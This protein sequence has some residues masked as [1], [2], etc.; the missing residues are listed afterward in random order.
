MKIQKKFT[1]GL[2]LM[3][4]FSCFPALSLASQAQITDLEGRVTM[5]ESENAEWQDAR[6]NAQLSIGYELKAGEKGRATIIFEAGHET[7]LEN[8]SSIKINELDNQTNL[9]LFKGKLH[10]KVKELS[11]TETYQITTPQ[12]ICGVR[13][14]EFIVTA[15]EDTHIKVI[16]GAVSFTEIETGQTTTVPAGKQ[17]RI[18]KNQAPEKPY[19]TEEPVDNDTGEQTEATDPEETPAEELADASE[20]EV[21]AEPQQEELDLAKQELRNEIRSA[22]I[23]IRA[24]VRESQNVIEHT[25]EADSVTGRSLKD[26]HGNLVR[27]EQHLMRPDSKT[28]QFINI[29]K[30]DNYKYKGRMNVTPT[31]ARLDSF[32][33]RVTFNRN[34]PEKISG[35]FDFVKDID[36]SDADFHPEIFKMT[37]N[38]QHDRIEM[39]SKWNYTDENMDEPEVKIIS[40]HKDYNGTWKIDS[41][42]DQGSAI[43]QPDD[44]DKAEMWAISPA[45]RVY[46]PDTS[47]EYWIRN[48]IENWLINNDGNVFAFK[49]L[50]DGDINPFDILK[51]IAF[52]T[53]YT[54]RHNYNEDHFMN[55]KDVDNTTENRRAA[56][57]GFN[58]ADN[59]LYRNFDLVVTPDMALNVLEEMAKNIDVSKLDTDE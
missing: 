25:R 7:R 52:Q 11:A 46:D 8:N 24:E 43:G 5:R 55:E 38:N 16:S 42:A 2:V 45:M 6:L 51:R 35:W 59:F 48:G 40:A 41:D 58:K 27:V 34:I 14:T 53:S 39:T 12:A 22:V 47:E 1:A 9:E 29:N 18:K 26:V 56:L 32:E 4:G 10:N 15:A 28:L 21:E 49:D 50:E 57:E 37:V 19:D 30:R 31:G 33:S 13:G 20:T 44:I 3:L 23:D 36:E 54:V 17:S